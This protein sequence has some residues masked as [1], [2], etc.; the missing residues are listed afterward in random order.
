MD[1]KIDLSFMVGAPHRPGSG[2]YA[3]G[4]CCASPDDPTRL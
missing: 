4:V 2:P 1:A 3:M